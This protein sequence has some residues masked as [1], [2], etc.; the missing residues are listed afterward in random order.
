MKLVEKLKGF[1]NLEIKQKVGIV[2]GSV[3]LVSILGLGIVMMFPKQ[4]KSTEP[5]ITIHD[6]K[7]DLMIDGKPFQEVRKEL[8]LSPTTSTGESGTQTTATT[9]NV[10]VISENGVK[11]VENTSNGEVTVVGSNENKGNKTVNNVTQ[12]ENRSN[13]TVSETPS[14]TQNQKVTPTPQPAPKPQPASKPQPAPQTW[15]DDE[16]ESEDI[17]QVVMGVTVDT[18]E[19]GRKLNSPELNAITSAFS[20][21]PSRHLRLIKYLMVE[22]TPIGML[23]VVNS[24]GNIAVSAKRMVSRI[25]VADL[26]A[27]LGHLVDWSGKY[28]SSPEFLEI[29]RKGVEQ[30]KM[31]RTPEEAFSE[32]YS[33]FYSGRSGA[34]VDYTPLYDFI[35][36]K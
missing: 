32:A 23:P 2:V 19:L 7:C 35:R 1:K 21:V 36:S 4:V 6:E 25:G 3:V 11:K 16:E 30:G 34:N 29:H 31:D 12:V 24:T 27:E 15:S 18:T 9:T 20:K 10:E 17:E 13:S 33:S 28:S 22:P 14:V 26:L 8:G 5:T